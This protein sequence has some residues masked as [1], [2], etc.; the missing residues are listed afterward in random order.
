MKSQSLTERIGVDADA[1]H[2]GLVHLFLPLLTLFYAMFRLFIALSS[3]VFM[4]SVL[5][6]QLD[7]EDV[8]RQLDG[9]Y[10]IGEVQADMR[11]YP[12]FTPAEETADGKPK[13]VGYAFETVDFTNLRGYSGKPIDLFVFW[14]AGL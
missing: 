14:T 6:G 3:C 1:H 8:S 5:G 11:A 9:R 4:H 12:V 7:R 13:L 10:T 2:F